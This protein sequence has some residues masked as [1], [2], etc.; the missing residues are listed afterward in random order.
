MTENF[1]YERR[2]VC[3]GDFWSGDVG[4]FVP[5]VGLGLYFVEGKCEYPP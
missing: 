3:H 2:R 5:F 4:R 1:T